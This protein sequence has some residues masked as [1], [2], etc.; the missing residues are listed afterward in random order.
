M[1]KGYT[2][3]FG[4]PREGRLDASGGGCER[5]LSELYLLE[6]CVIPLRAAAE[7]YVAFF[8]VGVGKEKS[9]ARFI[10]FVKHS[11]SG[12]IQPRLAIIRIVCYLHIYQSSTH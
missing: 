9:A 5:Y 4:A 1:Q 8:I 6:Q 3:K 2:V 7:R 12:C 10:K 11:N